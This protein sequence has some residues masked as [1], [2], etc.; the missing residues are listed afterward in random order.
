MRFIPLFICLAA[1]LT[2][3][4]NVYYINQT[5]LAAGQVNKMKPDGTGFTTLW[6]SPTVTD[7]RG[8]AVDVPNSRLFFA[9]SK[10]D[11]STLALTEVSL[12]TLPT[13]GGTPTVITTFPDGT[14]LGDVEWEPAANWIY[15]AVP[16]TLQLRR[17]RPDGSINETILTHTASGSAPYFVGIDPVG[18][19]AYWSLGTNPGDTNTSY[20]RG[21]LS[22]LVD[23]AWF[24]TTPSRTRD[25]AIDNSVPGSRLY[26][27]DRQNGAVYSRGP[28]SGAVQTVVSGLNAPHGLALDIEA[29]YAYV[30][31]TGKRGSANQASAHDVVR[32]KMDG[33]GGLEILSPFNAVAEPFDLDIDTTSVSYAD[34]RTRFFTSVAASAEPTADADGDGASNA[35]EYAFLTHPLKKDQPLNIIS[36]TSSGVRHARRLT[37]DMPVRV[38]ISTD[39]ST[40]HWNGDTPGAVWTS[41]NGTEPRDA[42]SQWVN[43]F[44]ASSL[45]GVGRLYFR[46]RAVGP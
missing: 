29:G 12:R 27:C 20:S 8:I 34:W 9:H 46:L 39:L 38:E 26:W 17:C 43:V 5:E 16:S 11:A 22:G 21:S 4:A 2:Q 28:E 42:D 41:E 3:A 23:G 24:L 40:W 45:A 30:A 10:Q 15:V 36:P 37:T 1:P 18:Q 25:I 31:D 13:T 44:P 33:S 6:T 35:T 14:F 32:F 7:L 19:R